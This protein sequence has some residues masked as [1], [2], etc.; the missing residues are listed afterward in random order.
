MMSRE[1]TRVGKQNEKAEIALGSDQL[2]ILFIR[3]ICIGFGFREE[4][5]KRAVGK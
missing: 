3:F 4:R 5:D 1:R 2:F